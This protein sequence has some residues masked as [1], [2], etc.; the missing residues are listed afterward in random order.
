MSEFD[1]PVFSKA[2]IAIRSRAERLDGDQIVNSFSSVGPLADLI[3]SHDHQVIYGR[4][5]TGKTHAL[6][7][8]YAS[9]NQEGD[10]GVFVDML[11]LGSDTSIYNDQ[12]LT[13]PERAT[14]LLIDTLAH[15]QDGFLDY[16][17]SGVAIDFERLGKLL[18]A[19]NKS[20]SQVRV[21][22]EVTR[23]TETTEVEGHTREAQAQLSATART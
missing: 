10:I 1:Q 20:T 13:I 9:I 11:K 18:D 16:A 2:L 17:T 21:S 3:S 4:R 15:I 6:R 23:T 22:G 8:L 14:R 5:G 12:S 19:F 7:Y